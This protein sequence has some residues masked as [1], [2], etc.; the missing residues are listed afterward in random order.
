M[1]MYMTAYF[2]AFLPLPSLHFCLTV[3]FWIIAHA[4][5]YVERSY[6]RMLRTADGLDASR[7][8]T[9]I[10]SIVRKVYELI[11]TKFN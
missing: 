6:V 7:S 10:R 2:D 5:R 1:F 8:L 9:G 4:A 3:H 11:E